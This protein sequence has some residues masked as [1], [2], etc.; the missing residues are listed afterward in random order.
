MSV[1]IAVSLRGQ[2]RALASQGI[3]PR[4]ATPRYGPF[5]SKSWGRSTR[6]CWQSRNMT[7]KAAMWTGMPR[8]TAKRGPSGN[9]PKP[10]RRPCEP[11]LAVWPGTFWRFPAP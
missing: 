10:K 1:R 2:M 11:K 5:C 3:S 7:R 6:P 4:T 9:C 8:G